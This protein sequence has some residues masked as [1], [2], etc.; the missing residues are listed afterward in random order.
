M[1]A[2]AAAAGLLA[3][4]AADER[5]DRFH[6]GP[7]AAASGQANSYAYSALNTSTPVTHTTDETT[8]MTWTAPNWFL[9]PGVMWRLDCV[10]DVTNYV[11]GT[12]IRW[13]GRLDGA[14]FP[15]L[16][17][18]STAFDPGS[19]VKGRIETHMSQQ[20]PQL[21]DYGY[22]GTTVLTYG[23]QGAHGTVRHN[24]SYQALGIRPGPVVTLEITVQL[25][26]N[27]ATRVVL[28]SARLEVFRTTG[29]LATP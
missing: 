7:A 14:D 29:Q 20:V 28:D 12:T 4:A 23:N 10:W 21:F 19:A 9:E 13:R 2:V 5:P 22:S 15:D 3:L 6:E 17:Y 18:D 11:P 1:Y 8:V 27:N 25:G 26:A 24:L 16:F